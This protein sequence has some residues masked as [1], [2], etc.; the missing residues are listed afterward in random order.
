VKNN[1]AAEKVI[2]SSSGEIVEGD[3]HIQ[4]FTSEDDAVAVSKKLIEIQ[5][6][7]S[8]NPVSLDDVF[9]YFVDKGDRKG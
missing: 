4:L 1:S 5:T 3:T 7:F 6:Q 2:R 9:F 8:I